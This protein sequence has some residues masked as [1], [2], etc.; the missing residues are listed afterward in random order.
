MLQIVRGVYLDGHS[1]PASE[2]GTSQQAKERDM[3]ANGIGVHLSHCNQGE[4]MGDCKYGDANCPALKARNWE[5]TV[6]NDEQIGEV[7]GNLNTQYF[8]PNTWKM[9]RQ[10]AEAQ[11]KITGDIAFKAGQKDMVEWIENNNYYSHHN[12]GIYIDNIDWN[13]VLKERGL[14]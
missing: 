3:E 12:D 10:V 7:Y 8:T 2:I 5:K 11:A 1:H 9:P 13:D 14:K 6:M 4:Y